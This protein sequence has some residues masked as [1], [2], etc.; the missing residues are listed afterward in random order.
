M[1]NSQADILIERDRP[2]KELAPL[3][4]SKI[5]ACEYFGG[6]MTKRHA[7][8]DSRCA[9]CSRECQT[10]PM[11]FIW[12]ANLHT[13]M[14]VLMSLLFT[15]LAVFAHHLYSRWIVVE[16]TTVHRLCAEC[17]DRHKKRRI[18]MA[19]LG[20]V[21]FA[22][23]MLPLFVTVPMFIFLLVIPFIAPEGF[24]K[25]FTGTIFGLALLALIILG[26]ELSR[27]A[28]IPNSLQHIGRF[29]FSLCDFRRNPNPR[30]MQ[31]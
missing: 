25:M 4:P 24:W 5:A 7:V 6:Y 14:T 11:N 1:T 9:M 3:F 15:A 17:Q 26:F 22:V 16:F 23:L 10:A 30:N 31:S 29:P 18:A 20:K 27:R 2:I 13:T 19:V 8:P 21:L 12:R 28:L